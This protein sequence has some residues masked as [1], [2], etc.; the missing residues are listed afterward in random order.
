[1]TDVGVHEAK[2]RLSELLRRVEA[3]EEVTIRRGRVVVARLIPAKPSG[4]RRLGIDVG[5][6]EVPEDFDASL[7][8]ATLASFGS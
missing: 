4:K 1:M 8:E 6:L 2:T 7:D 3:G 5:R